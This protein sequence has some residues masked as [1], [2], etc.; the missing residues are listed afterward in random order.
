[1]GMADGVAEKEVTREPCFSL[2]AACDV[3]RYPCSKK[4]PQTGKKDLSQRRWK[5]CVFKEA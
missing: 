4:C 1:M 2:L 3:I 5:I